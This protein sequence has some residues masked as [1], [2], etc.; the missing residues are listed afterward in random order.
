MEL[1]KRA[2]LQL[3]KRGKTTEIDGIKYLNIE[4][5]LSLL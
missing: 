3:G 2:N 4:E 5:Y 1:H